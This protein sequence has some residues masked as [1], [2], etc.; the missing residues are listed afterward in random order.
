MNEET[1]EFTLGKMERFSPTY[2]WLLS[3][4]ERLKVKK[5]SSP[6]S[7]FSMRDTEWLIPSWMF[8]GCALKVSQKR[9]DVRWTPPES[10]FES[11]SLFDSIVKNLGDFMYNLTTDA[12]K[13]WS[14]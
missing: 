9:D 8:N 4:D 3:D 10:W 13:F 6:F 1:G 14:E 11:R 7:L 5:K 2:G 12:E